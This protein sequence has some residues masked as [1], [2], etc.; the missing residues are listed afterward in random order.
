MPRVRGAR[1]LATAFA[2]LAVAAAHAQTAGSQG[3]K[4]ADGRTVDFT[5]RTPPPGAV[6]IPPAGTLAPKDAFDAARL[7]IS[8]LARGRIEDAAL[9]SNAPKQRYRLLRDAYSGW[10]A[11]DYARAY[12]R[13]FVAPNRIVAE[14]S[15][16]PH[17]L[18]LWKLQ[19][20]DYLAG[21]FFMDIDGKTYLDDWPGPTRADLEQ[22]LQAYR[23]GKLKLP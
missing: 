22:L 1:V 14:A 17:H 23:S 18:V 9:L 15:I 6:T 10:N 5:L 12:A 13:Y 4:L 8:D 19:D 16:G 21:Y 3:L 2:C 11:G 20:I 7:L